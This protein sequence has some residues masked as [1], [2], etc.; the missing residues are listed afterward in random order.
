[1]VI[2]IVKGFRGVKVL[3]LGVKTPQ[4]LSTIQEKF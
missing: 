1:M 3:H 4:G 2:G